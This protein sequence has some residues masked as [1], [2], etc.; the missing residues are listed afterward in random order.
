MLVRI[1]MTLLVLLLPFLLNGCSSLKCTPSPSICADELAFDPAAQNTVETQLMASANSI[2][3][4]LKILSSAQEAEDPPIVNTV[5]LMTPEGGMGGTATIDWTGP[6][7]PLLKR[8]A[9]LTDYRLK[10]LGNEPAIPIIV[11]ITSKH[12]I[13]AEIVQNAGY[14][15]AKRAHVL[16]YPET[17]VIELRYIL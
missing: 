9:D 16:V 17:R 14:Q 12:A 8:I 4:S 3:Q 10:I 2:E 7:A 6:I 11:T 13:I 15:A 5:P 1:S